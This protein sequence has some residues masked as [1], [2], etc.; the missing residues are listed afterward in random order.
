MKVDHQASAL[1]ARIAALEA[2]VKALLSAGAEVN[3]GAPEVTPP[4][5]EQGDGDPAAPSPSLREQ[6]DRYLHL[7]MPD[8]PADA[9]Q[10]AMI[11]R[12]RRIVSEHEAED[13]R[14]RKAVLAILEP[15]GTCC[16]NYATLW[17]ESLRLDPVPW[18][19]VM[20]REAIK[21]LE[22]ALSEQE[23]GE[24]K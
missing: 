8:D 9:I 23:E 13:E 18:S 3:E 22:Q 24:K 12:L 1:E 4:P 20:L 19:V 7:W 15:V 14:V 16:E 5:A 21:D 11:R 10:L 6:V 17:G 2:K